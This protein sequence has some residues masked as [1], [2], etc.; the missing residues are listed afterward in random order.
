[1]YLKPLFRKQHFKPFHLGLV[2]HIVC[3]LSEFELKNNTQPVLYSRQID[4]VFETSFTIADINTLLPLE[5]ELVASSHNIQLSET[6]GILAP[7][8]RQVPTSGSISNNDPGLATPCMLTLLSC[9]LPTNTSV[10]KEE[11]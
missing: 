2:F 11:K 8:T 5:F 10:N 4:E 3:G 7:N 1:M 9:S 6:K